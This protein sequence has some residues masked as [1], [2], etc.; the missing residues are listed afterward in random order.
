M[1]SRRL[2]ALLEGGLF[3]HHRS[4]GRGRELSLLTRWGHHA[5]HGRHRPGL[6]WRERHLGQL[7]VW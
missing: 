2:L 4:L 7:T 1:L 3:E 6:H 5:P